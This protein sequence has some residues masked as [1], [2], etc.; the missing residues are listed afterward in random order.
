[1]QNPVIISFD[2][3]TKYA[4][5]NDDRPSKL[6]AAIWYVHKQRVERGEESRSQGSGPVPDACALEDEMYRELRP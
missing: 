5:A 4:A 2:D 6:M 3:R 1:M